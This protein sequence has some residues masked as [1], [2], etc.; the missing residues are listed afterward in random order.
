MIRSIVKFFIAAAL[1]AFLP[2]GPSVA[3]DVVYIANNGSVGT[4]TASQPCATLQ[5]ALA[6]VDQG[7][8]IFCLDPTD[9]VETSATIATSVSIDCPGHVTVSGANTPAITIS[10][11]GQVVKIRNLTISGG[12][13]N[14]YPAISMQQGGTLI[15]ENCVI[16]NIGSGG[17]ALD[18]EPLGPLNL[19]ING[20]RISGNFGTAVLLQPQHN[21]SVNASLNGVTITTNGGG[22][23]RVDTANGPVTLNINGSEITYNAGNGLNVVGGSGGPGMLNLA[24]ST[25]AQNGAAGVQANGTNAAATLDDTLLDSNTSGALSAVSGGRIVT[26]GNNRIIGSPGSGFTGTTGLQ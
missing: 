25:V 10:G 17:P 16:E 19:V 20:G 9:I 2:A 3:A 7:G 4:C 12:T 1:A 15:L 18:I 24:H 5:G 26:Y 6:E 13:G 22:G 11:N 23:I 21:G 14:G 8:Q